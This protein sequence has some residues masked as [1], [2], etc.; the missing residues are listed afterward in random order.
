MK[1]NLDNK[2]FMELFGQEPFVV[3]YL[4]QQNQ[5]KPAVVVEN[6]EPEELPKLAAL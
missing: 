1:F 2:E 6:P 3:K 5:G 4:E